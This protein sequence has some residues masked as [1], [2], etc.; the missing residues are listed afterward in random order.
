MSSA[1]RGSN[2]ERALLNASFGNGLS[3]SLETE[4]PLSHVPLSS[5]RT[6]ATPRHPYHNFRL[7]AAAVIMAVFLATMAA[8][9]AATVVRCRREGGAGCLIPKKAVPLPWGGVSLWD[10][11]L[12][13]SRIAFGS[14]SAYDIRNQSVWD[15][16]VMPSQPDAWVWL[17][18]MYYGDEPLFNCNP[19]NSN[20]SACACEAT[21]M[22]QPP[23]MCPAGE[24][25]NARDKMVAQVHQPG[26]RA[27]LRYSCPGHEAATGGAM[28]PPG[29]DL[30]VCPRPVLG[31]YDDHD[32]G[33]NNF[34]RRL[35]AKHL[36]KQARP[37][38]RGADRRS[39]PWRWP[40][41]GSCLPAPLFR[42]AGLPSR[43]QTR[44]RRA[45]ALQVYLDAL[46]VAAD[47][48][49]RAAH[50]GIQWHYRLNPDTQQEVD[51]VLLDERYERAPLP[52][53][54]RGDW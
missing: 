28:V 54:I 40:W 19:A 27:F 7:A 22:R 48:P 20:A 14:C 33:V 32:Y 5:P 26:Y 11:H 9:V 38:P 41:R 34:N 31:V 18:D 30:A 23:Y 3:G 45:A 25:D 29:D 49:R 53:E 13:V 16:G 8:L 35:P 52:C 47:S 2:S 17:G 50:R 1:L 42:H 46:G 51:L 21:Y 15:Q 43:C 24:L 36:F 6:P 37:A 39:L 4:V 12:T 10:P 44:P